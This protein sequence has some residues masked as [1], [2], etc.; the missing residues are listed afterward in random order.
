MDNGNA[1]MN[2]GGWIDVTG[3]VLPEQFYGTDHGAK[4]QPE[5]RLMLAV[6]EDALHL[7]NTG[8]RTPTGRVPV[9]LRDTYRWFRSRDRSWPYSFENIC[10]ELG[11]PPDRIR[12]QV[13]PLSDV[14]YR[15]VP[16]GHPTQPLKKK[17]G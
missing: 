7:A 10:D 5:K 11:L 4:T 12:R 3:N 16:A 1:A 14:P 6:L 2:A 9:E 15:D 13:R 8:K 17:K